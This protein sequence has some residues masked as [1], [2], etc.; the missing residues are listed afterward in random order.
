MQLFFDKCEKISWDSNW[1]PQGSLHKAHPVY[2]KSP[3]RLLETVYVKLPHDVSIKGNAYLI[4]KCTT[5]EFYFWRVGNIFYWLGINKKMLWKKKCISYNEMHLWWN[6]FLTSRKYI[7]LTWHKQD[8][9]NW[10]LFPS[11]WDFTH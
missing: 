11:S 7:L 9:P 3:V 1:D 10:D 5:D 6:L 2:V 4:T 8:S